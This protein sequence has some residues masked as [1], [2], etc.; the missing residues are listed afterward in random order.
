[1]RCLD[2]SAELL[3]NSPNFIGQFVTILSVNKTREPVG[4]VRLLF[5]GCSH[6]LCP[7][8][9]QGAFAMHRRARN[10]AHGAIIAALYAVLTHMQNLILPG[11]ATWAI[12]LRFS[13]ALCILAFFTPAAAPGLA[14]GCLLFNLSFSAALPLD[15]LAG[16]LATYLAARGMWLTRRWKVWGVPVLGLLL[17]ALTN[18]ILV[19]WELAV[20]IGGG[21]WINGLYV[22]MGEA[23]VMLTLGT[24]LYCSLG[25]RNLN[26]RLFGK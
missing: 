14:V 15:F 2:F 10:L 8:F 3:Y 9:M 24:A 20:Y 18:G 23:A 22:A 7:F 13:E 25:K 5:V 17:P 26:K 16:T 11:S 19:G 21:F 1:M 4:A 6:V 12:Q